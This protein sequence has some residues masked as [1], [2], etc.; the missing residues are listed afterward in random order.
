M[1]NSMTET[2]EDCLLKALGQ[3]KGL[4]AAGARLSMARNESTSSSF[5][6]GRLKTVKGRE[7]LGYGIEVLI[8]GRIGKT[9]GNQV[10]DLP[11]MVQHAATLAKV[12]SVAHFDAFPPP[13]EWTSVKTHSER[14]VTLTRE[15]MIEACQ[16]V[17]DALMAYSPDLWVSCSANR[18][19]FESAFVTSGGVC[20]TSA[21][22]H[23]GLGGFVHRTQGTDMLSTGYGRGWRD[24]NEFFDPSA[25]SEHIL[26]ELKWGE[27]NV[28]PPVGRCK[29]YLPPK[30]LE[31]W[32]W[33][34]FMGVN[35]RN[36]AKGES[37][38]ADKLGGQVLSP[39]IT[40]VDNPHRD[41]SPGAAEVDDSG[42]PT[43][44]HTIFDKG[45][46]KLFL[47]DL[48]SAGLA[49][50]QPTGNS[51]CGA[52]FPHVLPG[53]RP[54]SE[55]LASI[56]DGLYICD[57]IGFGQSNIIN[58][59]FSCNVGL[60]YRIE[61]GEIVGRVKNTMVAGNLYELF[62]GN[63]ELSSDLNHTGC[64]PH[65]VLEDLNVSA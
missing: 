52:Y 46:L 37:P 44:K 9:Q 28:A 62:S 51:G 61:N 33:P 23:W 54:S 48:D 14:T 49:G 2:M 41:Y 18:A 65:A 29:A 43:K 16:T 5:E 21:G 3:A 50:A 60:G 39:N 40:I 38:L 55:L 6:A 45:V 19:E 59:D 64:Y 63:I 22:T 7:T 17:N 36:V 13:Q 35:G 56:E 31:M 57:L 20:R 24:L 26:Q 12:G 11:K 58:G 42:I 25:V 4:G 34:I 15:Q 47:Y 1:R 8:D 53:Q 32:L 30:T 27:K 10:D